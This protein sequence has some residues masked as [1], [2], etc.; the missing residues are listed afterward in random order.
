MRKK[1]EQWRKSKEKCHAC[2]THVRVVKRT[3]TGALYGSGVYVLANGQKDRGR[4]RWTEYV[5]RCPKC[6]E[7]F[8][9]GGGWGNCDSAL[10]ANA[11]ATMDK[12]R[13]R[14]GYRSTLRRKSSPSRRQRPSSEESK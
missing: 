10:L 8:F 13:K 1:P 12:L 4:V 11:L 3:R 14:L 9:T 6:G 7:Q 2:G 5:L